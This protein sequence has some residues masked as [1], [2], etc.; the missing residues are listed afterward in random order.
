MDPATHTLFSLALARAGASRLTRGATGLLIV[1]G[2]AA[3]LDLL[4]YFGGPN[5]FY[6]F[7]GTLL[8]SVTGSCLLALAIAGLAMFLD[9]CRAAQRPPG[10]PPLRFPGVLAACAIGCGGHLILDGFGD[11]PMR[12]WWPFYNRWWCLNFTATFALWI[13]LI[14][15]AGAALP[16]LFRLINEEIGERKKGPQ[17]SKGAVAALLLV[18]AAIG[19]R[20]WM[21]R[22]AEDLLFSRQYHGAAPVRAAAFPEIVTPLAWRG[23]VATDNSL[24]T[25]EVSFAPGSVFDPDRSIREYKPDPSPALDAAERTATAQLFLAYAQFPAASF[26][27]ADDGYRLVLRDLRYAS[28]VHGL[29]HLIAEIDLDL[30]VRVTRE[31]LRFA[32]RP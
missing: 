17:I 3:D 11:N 6:R 21:H 1:S 13:F 18:A 29:P 14:L 12:L 5:T 32:Q 8:H 24:E 19:W 7:H 28:D 22:R 16:A 31:G 23:V 26:Q 2:V 30:H 27:Q 25:L 20:G 10:T 15:L 9:R 4:S